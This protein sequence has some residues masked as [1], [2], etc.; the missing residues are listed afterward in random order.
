MTA[1]GRVGPV[2]LAGGPVAGALAAPRPPGFAGVDPG[3]TGALVVLAD[4][5]LTVLDLLEWRRA[6]VPPA[7][8]LVPGDVLALEAAYLGRSARAA[9]TLQLWRGRLLA[10]VPEGVEVTQP[11]AVHWR[12]KV[13]R[14]SNLRRAEAKA[15]AVRVASPYLPEGASVDACEAFCI[16]RWCWGWVRAG[17]PV[18]RRRGGP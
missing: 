12:A 10:A 8:P 6:S 2:A 7:L 14:R 18:A 16:A 17:R 13:L 5:G 4:D 1:P 15:A 3:A 11:L 9:L